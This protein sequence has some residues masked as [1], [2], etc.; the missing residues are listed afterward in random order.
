MTENELVIDLADQ[1]H[2]SPVFSS[3]ISMLTRSLP[4]R[5]DEFDPGE[6]RLESAMK[7]FHVTQQEDRVQVLDYMAI[8]SPDPRDRARPF[9]PICPPSITKNTD[10]HTRL[11]NFRH[12][13]PGLSPI[14]P[15]VTSKRSVSRMSAAMYC[16]SFEPPL[17]FDKDVSPVD[18]EKR[19][20]ETG[21]KI[22]GS[23]EMRQ[24][25][26]FGDLKPR[27]YF[28]MGGEDYHSSKYIRPIMNLLVNSFEETHFKTRSSAHSIIISRY[29]RLFT[30]DY[31]AFTSNMAEQKHFL[32]NLAEFVEDVEIEVL[33]TYE[34]LLIV[35]AGQ[36]IREY[37]QT[38]LFSPKFTM[39]RIIEDGDFA[40][41]VQNIAGFLGVYGNISSATALHG[42]H[43]GLL[44]GDG[45]SSRCV[46]DDVLG[47]C[48]IIQT[49]FSL[50]EG[51]DAVESIGKINRDKVQ[52]WKAEFEAEDDNNDTGWHYTKR[53]IDR[54]GQNIVQGVLIQFPIIGAIFPEEDGVHD[55]GSLT[56]AER[57]RKASTGFFRVARQVKALLSDSLMDDEV[58]LILSAMKMVYTAL[59]VPLGGVLPCD[60]VKGEPGNLF[61]PLDPRIFEEDWKNVMTGSFG[62]IPKIV[63]VPRYSQS[64]EA[65]TIS[66]K[67]GDE[68]RSTVGPISSFMIKMGHW[69]T[70]MVIEDW[71]MTESEYFDLCDKMFS[72]AYLPMYDISVVS[73]PWYYPD[74]ASRL[75]TV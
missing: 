2:V 74:L 11:C 46:G 22:M 12:K 60:R 32:M 25:W 73:I 33:D 42:I 3:Y 44:F 28:A 59:G 27:T 17:A 69:T 43:A 23:G 51:L 20:E 18:I 61:L 75:S 48:P 52:I 68:F 19:Y 38:C 34:G 30:Y 36:L 72:D 29:H 21:Q 49:A 41:F 50:D 5:D 63:A 14:R 35:S 62:E 6:T 7:E 40:Q 37:C 9:N 26:T 47:S 71:L 4:I 8:M 15:Q 58:E 10:F 13:L 31:E 64:P 56:F 66:T 16:S 55:G 65:C 54:I 67:M 57:L 53:P 24:T 45:S 70:E 1:M 39:N